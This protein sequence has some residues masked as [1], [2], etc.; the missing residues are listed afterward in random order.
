AVFFTFI[1]HW[2]KYF[3]SFA[4]RDWGPDVTSEKLWV[5]DELYRK[6]RW[7]RRYRRRRSVFRS[8]SQRVPLTWPMIRAMIVSRLKKR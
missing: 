7:H 1:P 6:E 2:T 8:I 4:K 5:P 3:D